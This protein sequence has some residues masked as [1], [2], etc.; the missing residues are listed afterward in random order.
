[1]VSL[2][3]VAASLLSI[4][5]VFRQLIDHGISNNQLDEIHG[6][7]YWIIL[8]IAVFSIGSFFRS[9]F[10][11]LITVKVISKLKTDTHSNLL[12][13]D[14]VAFEDLKVGDIISRLGSDI[15]LIGGLIINFLSFFIR[16]SI[17]LCGA[18]TLMFIQSPKLSLLVLVSI[19]L[20]L[21]P[22]LRLSKYVRR[23]SR[24][25][26]DEQGILASNIE[27]NFTAIRTLY[28]YNQQEFI[29]NKFNNHIAHYIKHAGLRFRARSLFFA[30]AIAI[31]AGSI[32]SVIW[33]G[34]VDILSGSMSS[35]QMISFIYYAVIVGTSAAGI[36]ELFSEIQA[37][38]AA[39]DRVLELKHLKVAQKSG[40]MQE[41]SANGGGSKEI[42]TKV[43][44][45][46]VVSSGDCSIRFEKVRFAYP[47]RADLVV[48]DGISLEIEHKKFTGIVGKSGSGK[49][50]LMQLLL[51]FYNHQS[52]DI[53]I[54]SDNIN[55]LQDSL[56]RSKIAYVEQHPTIFSGTIKSNIAFSNPN[57]TEAELRE[58]AEICGILDFAKDMK[59]GLDTPIGEKGVRI[60]GGQK[61]RIAIARALI[62]RPEILLLDEA[63][64]ALDNA[65]E[66]KILQNI[67]SLMKSKTIISIAHRISS[68]EDADIILVIDK[69][70]L[71]GS[72]KHAELLRNSQIYNVLYKEQSDLKLADK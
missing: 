56:I 8:L 39:L 33:I 23:L 65:S 50:T 30:L 12:K 52:G 6:A 61:Q 21:F 66:K 64:S 44:P 29:A 70:V 72:G 68:I 10:I 54:G 11:N 69:G 46:K 24:S 15:E 32:T 2:S 36:A 38:L 41:L 14:L 3:I 35:G 9:Y 67:R 5:Y 49:S 19:P 45:A 31:I 28:A 13:I 40:V 27:E 16:N 63:T 58:V 17:M 20:L 37:P 57:A 47:A 51:K 59:D 53:F 43:V 22:L 26:L 25:V 34:S 60:S 48:L 62:Y 1:M 42:P 55:T 18:I 71:E 4:G 7:I